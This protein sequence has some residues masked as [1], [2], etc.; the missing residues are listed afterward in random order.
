[1]AAIQILAVALA[2][3]LALAAPCASPT[4][5]PDPD[6]DPDHNHNPIGSGGATVEEIDA[7]LSLEGYTTS[8]GKS[9]GSRG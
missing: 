6:S 2:L 7:G 1:M 9:L 4:P 8:A 3:A 5:N